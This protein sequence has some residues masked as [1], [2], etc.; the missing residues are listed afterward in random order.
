[1]ENNCC[2]YNEMFENQTDFEVIK[3]K[4]TSKVCSMCEDSAKSQI[5]KGIPLA[6]VSCEG[7]CLRG[8]VSR[9]VANHICFK[10]E[11]E[12]TSRICLGGAFTKDTGQRSLVKK[13]K[14]VIVLEGCYIECA[15]RMLNGV[16]NNLKQEI[17]IV[18]KYYNFDK[19]LFAINQVTEEEFNQFTNEATIK[20][21]NKLEI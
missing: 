10:A 21:L 13:A 11:P 3:I 16:I 19:S 5:Q 20:I 18:D 8:E 17:I 7:A 2:N 14:R 6:I 4:K 1:M 9:R 12:K 15:S